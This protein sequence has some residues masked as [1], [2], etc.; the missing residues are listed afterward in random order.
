MA[1]PWGI[2]LN[3]I[4]EITFYFETIFFVNDCFVPAVSIVMDWI[5]WL[6]WL[7]WF[8]WLLRLFGWFFFFLRFFSSCFGSSRLT[9]SS[10]IGS[11]RLTSSSGIW[12][13]C[14]FSLSKDELCLC[15]HKGR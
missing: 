7:L 4:W 12:V 9:G 13:S 3:E 1:T 14:F 11:S 5:F 2:E 6:S 8:S 10:G 15:E